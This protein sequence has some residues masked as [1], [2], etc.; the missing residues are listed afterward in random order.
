MIGEIVHDYA[1]GKNGIVVGGPFTEPN[2]GKY[3]E[4]RRPLEWEWLVLYED[5]E[6]VGAD[7]ND[8]KVVEDESR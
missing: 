7:T 5:G 6:F 8:L 3:L 4:A 2:N 1:L